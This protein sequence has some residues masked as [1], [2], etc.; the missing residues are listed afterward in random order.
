MTAIRT[1]RIVLGVTGG[2]AAYKAVDLA[3]KLV[4]S[5]ATVDVVL[6]DGGAH[7]VG[8]A[9]FEAI[10]QR[11]VHRSVFEA[12]RADWH[13]H[14]SLGQRADL[15]VV[16]PATADSL[17]RLATGRADDMLGAAVLASRCPLLVASRQW[18]TRCFSILRPRRISRPWPA[19]VFVK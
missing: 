2:I 11:P 3:S 10:T 15:I 1:A 7:F 19:G 17:A 4:Q 16:A 6:T 14:I 9:S 13:G 12:W 18:N 8:E 5:G